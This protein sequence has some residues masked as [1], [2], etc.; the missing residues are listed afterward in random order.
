MTVEW[1][2]G[3]LVNWPLAE[4]K[5]AFL[6]PVATTAWMQE[7]EQCMEQLPSGRLVS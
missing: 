2:I 1:R 6:W 4:H 3:Q 7:V 5:N